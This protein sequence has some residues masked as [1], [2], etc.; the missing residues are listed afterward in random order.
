MSETPK[1]QPRM[2]KRNLRLKAIFEFQGKCDE[3][4][5]LQWSEGFRTALKATL[6]PKPKTLN[7][8]PQTLNPKPKTLNPKP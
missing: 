7:P 4:T 2:H 1:N 6:N 5:L 8:K 3:A